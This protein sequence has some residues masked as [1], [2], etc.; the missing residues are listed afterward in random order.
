MEPSFYTDGG[1]LPSLDRIF[2][3]SLNY[4]FKYTK[5]EICNRVLEGFYSWGLN[6]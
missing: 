4:S 6:D 2:S 5:Y 1:R 3:F